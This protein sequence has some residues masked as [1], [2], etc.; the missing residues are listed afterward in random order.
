[1][2]AGLSGCPLV[3]WVGWVGDY[4]SVVFMWMAKKKKKY[5]NVCDCTHSLFLLC[6]T[7]FLNKKK[8]YKIHAA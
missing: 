5:G 6:L 4:C 3:G 8:E 7:A 1:M 2:L